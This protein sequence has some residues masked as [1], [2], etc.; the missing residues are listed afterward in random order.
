VLPAPAERLYDMYLDP[1]LHAAFTGKPV[2]IAGRAGAPFRAFD[3]ALTGA[4][5]HVAPKRQIAQ[6]WRSVNFPADAIDSVLILTFWPL[7]NE[8]RVELQ[9][10]NVPVSDFAGISDGWQKFYF[11]PWRIY[12]SDEA[13]R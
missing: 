8:G 1:E 12:L 13:N 9:H 7:G 2:T 3:G 11:T 6:L 10:I 4:I 5:L